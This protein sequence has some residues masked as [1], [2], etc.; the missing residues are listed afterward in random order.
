MIPQST[1]DTVLAARL[2]KVRRLPPAERPADGTSWVRCEELQ[3]ELRALLANWR[4]WPADGRCD[5]SVKA[6]SVLLAAVD[7]APAEMEVFLPLEERDDWDVRLLGPALMAP[8]H[9]TPRTCS[10]NYVLHQDNWGTDYLRGPESREAEPSPDD[11]L[12]WIAAGYFM[13]FMCRQGDP[14]FYE[15]T[16]QIYVLLGRCGAVFNSPSARAAMKA[17]LQELGTPLNVEALIH[18]THHQKVFQTCRM[19][20]QPEESQHQALK[21]VAANSLLGRMLALRPDSPRTCCIAAEAL[22][23]L[24]E[25]MMAL[26]VAARGQVAEEEQGSK[27]PYHAARTHLLTAMALQY[28]GLAPQAPVD[29]MQSELEAYRRRK[30]ECRPWLPTVL[31]NSLTAAFESLPDRK[32]VV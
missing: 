14:D 5:E 16:T 23:E 11:L 17:R 1:G 4:S 12:K 29:A 28:G 7:A 26:S 2:D 15:I 3:D 10:F 20:R 13:S 27:E 31:R 24:G 9:P 30:A 22:L 19:W 6:V 32:S 25:P 8:G 18:V 21:E